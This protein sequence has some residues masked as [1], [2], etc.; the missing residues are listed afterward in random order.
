M[1]SISVLNAEPYVVDWLVAK[2]ENQL[3]EWVNDASTGTVLKIPAWFC[4]TH[5]WSIAG[6]IIDRHDIFVS[7]SSSDPTAYTANHGV[8]NTESVQGYYGLSE[9]TYLLAA[10]KCFVISKL[11]TVVEVPQYL[12]TDPKSVQK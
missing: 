10:I 3:E 9:P 2:V 5:T 1:I 6:P 7:R 12:I 4:P 8:P 11:G